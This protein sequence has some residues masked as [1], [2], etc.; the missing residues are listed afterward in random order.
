MS[1]AAYLL[2]FLSFGFNFVEPLDSSNKIAKSSTDNELSKVK[3]ESMMRAEEGSSNHIFDFSRINAR[4]LLEVSTEPSSTDTPEGD[5]T[6]GDKIANFYADDNNM[7]L[8][9]V[10]PLLILVYGG[11]SVIYC[12]HKCRRHF[13]KKN[14]TAS[15]NQLLG[16]NVS[17]ISDGD[18]N[19]PAPKKRRPISARSNRIAPE[20]EIKPVT[21]HPKL[22]MSPNEQVRDLLTDYEF[23]TS[24]VI[25]QKTADLLKLHG[26]KNPGSSLCPTDSNISQSYGSAVGGKK[27]KLVFLS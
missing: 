5:L 7:A 17:L 11:C 16:D 8:Y 24:W 18:V 4:K 19:A 27:K 13:R 25:A 20:P 26:G 9:C 22:K 2:V 6:L 10:L 3:S 15:T 12:V 21:V 14:R 23:F 1:Y